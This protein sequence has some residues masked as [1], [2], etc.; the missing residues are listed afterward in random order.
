MSY[1]ASTIKE[2]EKNSITQQALDEVLIDQ[3]GFTRDELS[4]IFAEK[5]LHQS[6]VSRMRNFLTAIIG[7]SRT[8]QSTDALIVQSTRRLIPLNEDKRARYEQ[9]VSNNG[10]IRDG[11]WDDT[12]DV[13]ALNRAVYLMAE[14]CGILPHIVAR[15]LELGIEATMGP[16]PSKLGYWE[17]AEWSK[18]SSRVRKF[19]L[20]CY[21]LFS[22]RSNPWRWFS[23]TEAD[24]HSDR[25]DS[26]VMANLHKADIRY[27]EL[28]PDREANSRIESRP[29]ASWDQADVLSIGRDMLNDLAISDHL[30]LRTFAL[31]VNDWHGWKQPIMEE[32]RSSLS[33]DTKREIDTTLRYAWKKHFADYAMPA[34][35]GLVYKIESL[36][37]TLVRD[38]ARASGGYWTAE[39]FLEIAMYVTRLGIYTDELTHSF[40]W[41]IKRYPSDNEAYVLSDW[42]LD[43][44]HRSTIPFENRANLAAVIQHQDGNIRKVYDHLIQTIDNENL[45]VQ[46]LCGDLVDPATLAELKA[47]HNEP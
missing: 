10:E 27:P 44:I 17:D 13:A 26:L 18:E 31:S 21:D 4:F 33:S 45:T 25:L 24:T 42:Q 2:S 22:R 15:I 19:V 1:E 40:F 46:S 14:L 3:I 38:E 36:V 9:R 20:C 34:P 28:D 41:L 8:D 7:E 35:S 37:S 16:V 29:T 6:S 43:V 23:N 47:L 32:S 39:T 30:S 11:P 5:A 12:I